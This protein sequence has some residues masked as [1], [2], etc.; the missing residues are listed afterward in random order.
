MV[1]KILKKTVLELLGYS[2]SISNAFITDLSY[3]IW[4]TI[5]NSTRQ[6][7][8][9]HVIRAYTI[10]QLSSLYYFLPIHACLSVDFL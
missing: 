4:M 10:S 5:A 1:Y 6:Y 2:S 3:T 9:C 8:L 7:S